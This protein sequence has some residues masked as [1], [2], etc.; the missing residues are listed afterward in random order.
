MAKPWVD[1]QVDDI[2]ISAP[3]PLESHTLPTPDAAREVLNAA[4]TFAHE[5]ATVSV[6]ASHFAYVAG[7]APGLDTAAEFAVSGLKQKLGD[8]NVE[9][10]TSETEIAGLPAMEVDANLKERDGSPWRSHIVIFANENDEYV[11]TM[12]CRADLQHADEAWQKLRASI[13]RA[14]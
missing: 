14:A 1:Q 5:E 8:P 4:T 13:K 3:W 7:H 2:G 10:K 6:V 12:M 9:A 11:V